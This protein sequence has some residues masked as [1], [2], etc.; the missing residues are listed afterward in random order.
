MGKQLPLYLRFAFILGALSLIVIANSGERGLREKLL[1]FIDDN[2]PDDEIRINVLG[3]DDTPLHD[4]YDPF[5]YRS[6]DWE[7]YVVSPRYRDLDDREKRIVL[8]ESDDVRINTYGSLGLDL[9]YGKSIFTRKRYQENAED[10]PLSTVITDGF[11]P[12][13]NLQIHVEGTIGDR[14]TIY[15]DHDSQKNDNHYYFKYR[16]LRDDELIRELNAGEIDINF[17]GSKY[18]VYDNST[19]KGIGVDMTLKK[20]RFTFKAFG[21]VT[22]GNTEVEVFRGNSTPGSVKLSEFQYLKL[23]YYQIEPLVRY[24][25]C[26]VP[27]YPS[28]YTLKPVQINPYGFELYMDDQNPYNNQGAVELPLYGG[29][30][31]KMQSGIDYKINYTTGLIQFLKPLPEKA[32]VF[33]VYSLIGASTDPYALQPGDPRHPGGVFAGRIFT[34][35]KYGYTLEDSPVPGQDHSQQDIYE[36]RS[37]YYIGDRHLMPDNFSLRFFQENG[38][39]TQ[40]DILSLGRYSVDYSGGLIQFI[41]REPF[42]ELLQANG[43][44]TRIYVEHQPENVYDYSRYRIKL[45]YYREA[46][47]FQLNHMNIIPDSLTVKVDGRT[48]SETRYTVDYTAGYINFNSPHDPLIGPETVIEIRY[49]YLP[50]FA[51]QQEFVGGFRTEYEFSRDLKIGGSLLYSRSAGDEKI[52]MAG[53]EPTQTVFLEADATLNLD[54]RRLAQFANIFTKEKRN[55]LPLE[56]SG[57]AEYARS[58]K[59]TNTFGKGLVDNMEAAEDIQ[60]LSMSERDWI[61]SSPPPAVSTRAMLKYYYFRNPGSPALLK[62]IEYA[63]VA[64]E[65][66]YS[67]KPGPFNVAFGH[68]ANSIVSLTSQ[69]SLVLDFSA[70]GDF[71]S[72]VT[73]NIAGEAIDLSGIQYVEFSYLYDGT[74][75]V[76]LCLEVGKVNEDSDGDGFLDTEDLNY[77]GILDYDPRSGFSEDVGYAF[78]ES[79]HPATRVGGGLGFNAITRGDGVLNTEDLNGNGTLDTAENIFTFHGER[80]RL[81]S[82][83]KIWKVARIYVDQTLLTNSEI[84]ALK[85]TEAV[86]L[87]VLKNIGDSGRIYID[88]IKFVS[89]KWRETRVDSNP[90]SPDDL[91]VS[92]INNI[93]DTEYKMESFSIIMRDIYKAMYGIDNNKELL[94]ERE[95]SLKLEYAVP[96]GS[97]NVSVTR[98]FP[99]PMDFRNY[100][101]L[102]A[103]INFRN[104]VPGDEVGIIVGSSDTDYFEYKM[105]MEYPRVWR[106]I[107]M[108]LSNGSGGYLV[109]V[110]I[111]GIPDMKRINV[112]KIVIYSSAPPT[113]GSFWI[114]EIYLEEPVVQADS[115]HWYEGEIR[116]TRPFYRTRDGMPVMSDFTI[117][118]INKGHGAKFSTI[119][120]KDQDIAEEYHQVFS[121]FSILPNWNT[122]IDYIRED[123]KTDSLNEEVE[124]SRR[125]KTTKNSVIV[126]TDYTSEINGVP[127]VRLFYRYDDYENRLDERI[128]DHDAKREKAWVTHAPVIYYRQSIDKFLWGRLQHEFMMNM[129]FK[130]E[131]VKRKS[132]GGS[133]ED[134]A[135]SASL[136]EVERRQRAEIRYMLDYTN[137]WFYFRPEILASSEE[138]VTWLGKSESNST[139]ILYAVRGGY[140]FPFVYDRDCRFVERNKSF[141][142]SAGLGD[143]TYL[144]PGYKVDIQYFEN[145]FRDYEIQGALES[146]YKRDRDARTL[147]STNIDVPIYLHKVK[148]LRFVRTF[149]LNY[150]RSLY[151]SEMKVPYEGEQ[152]NPLDERYGMTRSIGRLADAGFN[153]FRYYPF[154]FFIG[155][156]NYARGRDYLYSTMNLPVLDRG[157]NVVQDYDNSLRLLDNFSARWSVDFDKVTVTSNS[158]LHQVCERLNLYGIPSQ[159]I[160]ANFEI[161]VNFDLMRLLSFWFFRPN[162]EGIPYH[163]AFLTAGYRFDNNQLV[164]QNIEEQVHT[165]NAGLSFKRDRAGLAFNFGVN[166]KRKENRPFISLNMLKRSY[167]DQKYYDNMPQYAFIKEKDVGYIF[168]IL[169][170]TDVMWIYKFFSL[171]Y[172]LSAFP[173]YTLEYSM[174]MNRYDYT[175]TVQPEPY[176]LHLITSKLSL[177][178][179]KNI[180]GGISTRFALEQY[181]NRYTGNIKREV[182][183]FEIGANFTLMF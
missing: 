143:F 45:D 17:K 21:S 109:P 75:D 163:A 142:L 135:E 150:N 54:G 62:G 69:L 110:S 123:S 100:K 5:S 4:G 141:S 95:T 169:L 49:E 183:S 102:T 103:W 86:R 176:D 60:A 64:P 84:N 76:D 175:F 154:C 77:N 155:R 140:H 144:A 148:V 93:D 89:S 9:L 6:G 22:R 59:Q 70:D 165:P 180:Q 55:S 79:G 158:G 85:D 177:N 32:R 14:M 34:F 19:A 153:I 147:L 159:V 119:G 31:T 38:I 115:A 130:K 65:I 117:K 41:Y 15:I 91:K 50:L 106:E 78:N 63:T 82:S 43:T 52:P 137:K 18:A 47:S 182:F 167:K 88:G 151:F 127:S 126:S 149:A 7:E 25:N 28:N 67:I 74:T 104:F 42:R 108:R 72:I 161:N 164:T 80:V 81:D 53:S 68:V 73:R 134:I 128:L 8:H 56:I 40:K 92:S 174:K 20:D 3:P 24:D 101:T 173:V 129:S 146:G 35:L 113:S 37:F 10:K 30:Y 132:L 181:R 33:A 178:L 39:M 157:G 51:Q 1:D 23:V 107:K 48:I 13:Q 94:K 105:Q 124:E 152:R 121:S 96:A 97:T 27:P 90:A 118:Y 138:V 111:S 57:Y 131:E 145:K 46:R 139:E 168:S 122:T 87:F 44:V 160:T 116:V 172:T 114:N 156:E 125:G 2:T 98:R 71:A 162:K 112:L 120:K 133:L 99:K 66:N 170:E 171:F 179:H 16:A 136:F 26:L 12:K 36:V 61:L 29:L 11:T 166:L 83:Q 58:Y